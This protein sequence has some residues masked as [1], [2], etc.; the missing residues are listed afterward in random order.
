MKIFPSRLFMFRKKNDHNNTQ[1]SHQTSGQQ[2]QNGGNPYDPHRFSWKEMVASEQTGKTSITLFISGLGSL[3]TAALLITLVTL[4]ALKLIEAS[5]VLALIENVLTYYGI[6][7]GLLGVRSITSSFGGNKV[8][9]SNV[10]NS[11]GS[12][13]MTRTVKRRERNYYG[14]A[15]DSSILEAEMAEAMEEE[16]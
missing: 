8:S 12:R 16:Q 6:S 2:Q 5:V 13:T 15:T 7:V 14:G 10:T 9:I 11:D 3:V 4:C 1:Q